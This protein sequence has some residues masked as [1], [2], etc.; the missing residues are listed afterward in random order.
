M[1]SNCQAC[2]GLRHLR[3]LDPTGSSGLAGLMELR[4]SGV[5]GDHVQVG[6]VCTGAQR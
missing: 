5:I 3:C 2:D 6:I 4:R 1:G